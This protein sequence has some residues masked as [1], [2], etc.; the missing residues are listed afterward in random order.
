MGEKL[1]DISGLPSDDSEDDDYNPE[2]PDVEKND[3]GDESSS[4]ES[5]FFSASEDLEEV[6]PKDDE[7]LALP[8]EE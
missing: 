5:D 7:I 4:D 1:D 6:P 8:S 2:N 3:S